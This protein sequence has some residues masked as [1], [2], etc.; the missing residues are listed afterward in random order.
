MQAL[1]GYI[2]ENF[3]E[4]LNMSKTPL[5]DFLNSKIDKTGRPGTFRSDRALSLAAGLNENTVTKIIARGRADRETLFKL[6]NALLVPQQTLLEISGEAVPNDGLS[7]D[8]R[9]FLALYQSLAEW[10]RAQQILLRESR[11]LATGW[12]EFF[13]EEPRDTEVIQFPGTSEI[14]R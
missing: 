11:A 8:E 3:S 1:E 12:R 2:R 13:Q 5:A 14:Q 4:H 9:E 7:P 10:P 6:A